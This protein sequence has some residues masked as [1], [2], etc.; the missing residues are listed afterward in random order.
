MTRIG[1]I[2]RQEDYMLAAQAGYDFIEISGRNVCRMEQADFRNLLTLIHGG[3]L[4]CVGF[5]AY[6]TPDI[7]IAGPGFSEEVIRQYA[8]LCC[9]RAEMLGVSLIGIGSPFS[10]TLPDGFSRQRANEQAVSF[11]Q[12]TADVFSGA[13]ITVCVEALAGCYCNFINTVEE[14]AEIVR[15]SDRPN[16]KL[17]IDFYNMEHAREADIDLSPYLDLIA[18][19]HISDDAGSPQ[20]RW[21]LKESK[22]LVHQDRVRRLL[23]AGYQGDISLEVDLPLTLKE[24]SRSLETLRTA[25]S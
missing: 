1:C 18:H 3:T 13:G 22:F 7:K 16:L 11:Y 21:F 14:A 23:H 12:I 25:V 2:I 9:E 19:V 5:N 8:Y 20:K 24:A 15:L 6:C 4:P 17:V 10:R